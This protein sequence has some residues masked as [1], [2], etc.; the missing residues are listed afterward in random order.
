MTLTPDPQQP[1]L[2]TN[3]A[4]QPG[5][6]GT[7]AFLVG[8]STY[9]HLDGGSNPAPDTF[10][11]PQLAVSAWTA[12]AIFEWLRTT[13]RYAPAP[14]AQC[15]LLLAPTD[16]EAAK[17]EAAVAASGGPDVLAHSLLPT[18]NT[19]SDTIPLWNAQMVALPKAAAQ[20]SRLVF[21]GSGHGLEI[22]AK[23]YILLPTDYLRLP[24]TYNRA[25]NVRGLADALTKLDVC[26]QFLFVDACRSTPDGLK[27]LLV[28]GNSVLTPP[29]LGGVV[30]TACNSVTLCATA[31]GLPAHQNNSPDNGYSLFGQALLDGLQS[32]QG[33]VPECDPAACAV[34][35]P[36]LQTFI[37]K[38]YN[39]LLTEAQWTITQLTY[40]RLEGN[41]ADLTITHVDPPTKP[42]PAMLSVIESQQQNFTNRF[43]IDNDDPTTDVPFFR[44][45]AS[46]SDDIIQ[47][48]PDADVD[49]GDSF[50]APRTT[51]NLHDVLGRESVTAFWDNARVYAIDQKRLLERGELLLLRVERTGFSPLAMGYRLTF[52]LRLYNGSAWLEL[53]DGRTQYGIMLPPTLDYG[54]YQPSYRLDFTVTADGHVSEL[55][56]NLAHESTGNLGYVADVWEKYQT[57]NIVSAAELIDMNFLREALYNK[58]R[59]PFAALVAA[60]VLLQARR[61]DLAEGDWLRNLAN[62]FPRLPD[63]LLLRN[64]WLLQT[65]ARGAATELIDN[66][67]KLKQRGT[68]YTNEALGMAAVQLDRLLDSDLPTPDQRTALTALRDQLRVA[69]RYGRPGGLLA[70]FAGDPGSFTPQ[71]LG[72]R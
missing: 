67:L 19:I 32:Q 28:E 36:P 59:S 8:V 44:Y 49:G 66:L 56:A 43:A 16:A 70:V 10:G 42:A 41:S 60:M 9:D 58:I 40:L 6:P 11:M 20:A 71:L 27:K 55:Q 48:A 14:L 62:R 12:Y 1:G 53:N 52:S 57:V 35:L 23:E 34:K 69:L 63:G 17:I 65:N 30:N 39:Q 25:L 24:D 18:F 50:P 54:F 72:Y 45:E 5:T 37:G 15:W 2:W 46:D 4:W 47:E 61:Y 51:N 21:F 38:R 64:Q 33:F 29:A 26:D 68:P 13:Y 22:R 3:P 7:F 31:S